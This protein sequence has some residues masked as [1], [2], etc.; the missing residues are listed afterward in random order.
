M[1][2]CNYYTCAAS[3]MMMSLVACGGTSLEVSSIARTSNPTQQISSLEE[4]IQN[5]RQ[6]EVHI[7][8]PSWFSKSEESLTQAQ[9]MQREG[10]DLNGIFEAVAQ[11][12]AQIEKAKATADISTSTL[13]DAIEARH[14]ALAAG[15]A[16]LETPFN[17]AEQNFL[18]LTKEVEEGNVKW[19]RNNQ[20]KVASQFKALELGAIKKQA[21]GEAR[22]VIEK[23]QKRDAHK[24]VPKSFALAK[25]KLQEA[26]EFISKNRY[27]KD[28]LLAKANEALFYAHRM[29]SLYQYA[30]GVQKRSPEQLALWTEDILSGIAKVAGAPDM[31]NQ[32][33]K[34]QVGN[35]QGKIEGLQKDQQFLVEMTNQQSDEISVLRGEVSALEGMT[36]SEQEAKERLEAEKRFNRLYS[37]VRTYFSPNEAEVYKQGDQLLI[38]LKSMKFPVGQS[39]IM[40]SNYPILTKVQKAIRTFGQPTVTIEG[41]T[42]TT[43]SK[44]LNEH[45]SRERAESVKQYFLANQTLRENKLVSVGYGD[46]KPV[47]PN[48]TAEGRAQNRRID[49]VISPVETPL[50]SE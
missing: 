3:L 44:A 2:R 39:V 13:P 25:Q 26:D 18:R 5:A 37:E 42:D 22:Q 34:T 14:D 15:A 12:K 10:K 9:S 21:L 50:S 16:S 45:L 20:E 32:S 49:V 40:P 47:A 19:A 35:I 48:T 33:F 30:A 4:E 46:S 1:N 27:Q 38:R 29:S 23:A 41:H 6:R 36:K 17:A 31:R 7:L 24:L 8:S 28:Q 43:G 11:G